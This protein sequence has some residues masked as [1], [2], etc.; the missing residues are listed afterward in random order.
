[1]P[2]AQIEVKDLELIRDTL[3][4]VRNYFT[5]QDIQ[6]QAVALAENP[7]YSPLTT[8]IGNAA[9]RVDGILKDYLLAEHDAEE[10]LL[11]STPHDEEE[12]PL[13]PWEPWDEEI[14][15]FANNLRDEGVPLEQRKKAIE[16]FKSARRRV[17]MNP[18]PE[19]EHGDP[20]EGTAL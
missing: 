11:E 16:Q 15:K 3:S 14:E 8:Q 17:R 20:D 4:V 6:Y 5:M 7:R 13:E 1:M 2:F 9:D 18:E 12:Y 10:P 19:P